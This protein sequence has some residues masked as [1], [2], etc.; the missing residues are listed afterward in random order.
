MES[1]PITPSCPFAWNFPSPAPF[2]GDT[3]CYFLQTLMDTVV[4]QLHTDHSAQ[5]LSSN[6]LSVRLVDNSASDESGVAGNV[7]YHTYPLEYQIC[8]SQPRQKF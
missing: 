6:I 2:W 4:Q 8:S 5:S 1:F 3:C 7:L